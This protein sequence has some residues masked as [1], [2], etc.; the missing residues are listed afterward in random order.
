MPGECIGAPSIGLGIANDISECVDFCQAEVD[1][2]HSCNYFSYSSADHLCILSEFCPVI[3]DGE[4]TSCV[5]GDAN[6]PNTVCGV[7]GKSTYVPYSEVS[8]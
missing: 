3:S 1:L 5:S 6:C 4:C 7:L 8:V 2:G